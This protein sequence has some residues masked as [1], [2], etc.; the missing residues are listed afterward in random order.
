MKT[1]IYNSSCKIPSKFC[2]YN[3]NHQKFHLLCINFKGVKMKSYLILFLII[4][5]G[6]IYAQEPYPLKLGNSWT[7]RDF[8]FR[9]DH[10]I[11]VVDSNIIINN[12]KYYEIYS[13][14]INTPFTYYSRLREDGYYVDFDS[15]SLSERIY[16]KENPK[17]GDYWYNEYFGGYRNHYTVIDTGYYLIFGRSTKFFLVFVTDSMLSDNEYYWSED[18]GLL[19]YTVEDP[20]AGNLYWLSGCLIDGV[21]YGDTSLNPVSVDDNEQPP[22]DYI[23]KQNYPNPFNPLTTIDFYLPYRSWVQLKIYDLLGNEIAEL[24]NEEKD[25]GNYQVRF[26]G[27]EL[28]SGIYFYKLTTPGFT[29][30][31]KMILTK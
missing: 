21:V 3:Y 19:Q 31:R 28:S 13:L 10:K 14:F 22:K 20:N 27:S 30:A 11:T 23:L 7:T 8:F 4:L 24:V 17:I 16:F 29:K 6:F 15:V 12:K 18:F 1:K 2:G 9:P 5:T 26:N 25:A